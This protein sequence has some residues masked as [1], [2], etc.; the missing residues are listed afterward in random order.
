MNL[1]GSNRVLVTS[2]SPGA[3]AS[4][5]SW[6]PDGAR[7]VFE[8]GPTPAEPVELA[9]VNADGSGRIQITETTVP[10]IG[11]RDPD[12]EGPAWSPDGS[13]IVFSRIGGSGILH[14]IRPDGGG[15]TNLGVG[16]GTPA[17]QPLP[18]PRRVRLQERVEVLQ[19]VRDFLGDEQ[20]AEQYGSHGKCVGRKG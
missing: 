4:D 5:P 7:I 8:S 12:E 9:V 13:L 11:N 17:W 14:T 15:V 19:G 2:G 20:F 3:G 10:P 1:D 6:S 16:G 18:G